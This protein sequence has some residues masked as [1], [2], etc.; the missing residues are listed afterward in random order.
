MVRNSQTWSTGRIDPASARTAS[1]AATACSRGIRNSDW[2]SSPLLGVYPMRKV[3]RRSD[4][5]PG[6]PSCGVQLTGSMPRIGCRSSV[7]ARA[8]K[9][10]SRIG[11]GSSVTRLLT[12]T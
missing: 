11:S 12:Q 8:P 10:S 5:R 1:I 6:R 9:S 7:A 4:Q 3:G 2:S